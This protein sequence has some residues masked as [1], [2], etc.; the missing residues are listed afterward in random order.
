MKAITL[1]STPA[2]SHCRRAKVYVRD[3]LRN[4]GALPSIVSELVNNETR[5]F[6]I[7]T[8]A[9]RQDNRVGGITVS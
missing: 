6:Y 7:A 5:F 9:S 8:D 3:W 2:T 1:L 4:P